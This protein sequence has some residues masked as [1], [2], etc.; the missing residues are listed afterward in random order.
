MDTKAIAV[1]LKILQ[2]DM[3]QEQMAKFIG[4]S[5]TTLRKRCR[6]PE[7]LTLGEIITICT[8]FRVDMVRFLTKKL[9][10]V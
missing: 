8:V 6:N 7:E 5:A 3:T 2:A 1:N 9:W 4:M 10:E